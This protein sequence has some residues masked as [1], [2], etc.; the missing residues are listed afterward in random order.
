MGLEPNP[1]ATAFL[2]KSLNFSESHFHLQNK[3][4]TAF[5]AEEEIQYMSTYY[6]AWVL[7]FKMCLNF[8]NPFLFLINLNT[9]DPQQNDIL[10][11][12]C[13]ENSQGVKVPSLVRPFFDGWS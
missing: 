1:N 12:R 4:N 13:Q 7:F 8:F 5:T 10:V 6:N 11:E 9:P 3:D 2:G